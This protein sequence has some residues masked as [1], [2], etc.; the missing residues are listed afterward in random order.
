M[1]ALRQI[2][3]QQFVVDARGRLRPRREKDGQS[4]A[5]LQVCSPYDLQ[6]RF[7]LRGNTRW[8][9]YLAQTPTT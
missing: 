7:V 6:A 3:V 1:E 9:G 5:G 4:P 2:M 8:T